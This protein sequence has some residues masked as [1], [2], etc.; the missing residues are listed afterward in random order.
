MIW[1]LYL[2]RENKLLLIGS[3]LAAIIVLLVI[4]CSRTPALKSYTPLQAIANGDVVG[5]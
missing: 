5:E 1:F 2:I 4:G 3:I